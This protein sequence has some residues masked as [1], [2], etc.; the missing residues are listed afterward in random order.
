MKILVQIVFLL[1]ITFSGYGQY[2]RDLYKVDT[3]R[4]KEIHVYDIAR[5]TISGLHYWSHAN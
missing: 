3:I 5:D 4:T 1:S 2:E